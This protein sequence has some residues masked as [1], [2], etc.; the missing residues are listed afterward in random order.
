MLIEDYPVLMKVH[1]LYPHLVINHVWRLST[2]EEL[3]KTEFVNIL[4]LPGLKK[5][6]VNHSTVVLMNDVECV[7]M[8]VEGEK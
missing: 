2:Q 7:I 8:Y 5:I 3:V 6:Q 1:D 4:R